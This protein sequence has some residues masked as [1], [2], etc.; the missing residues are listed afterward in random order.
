M[1]CHCY[2]LFSQTANKYYVGHTCDSLHERLRKHNSDHKG[3]T[4]KFSDWIVVYSEL[5]E[6]REE[7]YQRER[8]IKSWKSRR[9]IKALIN[10]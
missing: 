10:A 6:S 8:Q 4:G 2:I 9:A 7:A 5:F 1:S 3:F